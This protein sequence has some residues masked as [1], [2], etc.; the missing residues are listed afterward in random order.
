[1]AA[2]CRIYDS[3]AGNI[4][5]CRAA[6]KKQGV[7]FQHALFFCVLSMRQH[8]KLFRNDRTRG[9]CT[10][11]SAAINAGAG[12]NDSNAGIAD[13]DSA[14]GASTFASAAADAGIGNL[15]CHSSVLLFSVPDD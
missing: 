9:A 2:L 8:G 13:L 7:L 10:L 14:N 5:F 15:M 1:M 12:I 3:A 6:H 11:A 4:V